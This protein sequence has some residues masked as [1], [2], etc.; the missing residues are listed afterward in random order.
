MERQDERLIRQRMTIHEKKTIN[1]SY[2]C[3]ACDAVLDEEED[4]CSD[5]LLWDGNRE[6]PGCRYADPE[7]ED[8]RPLFPYFVAEVAGDNHPSSGTEQMPAD[9]VADRKAPMG[10]TAWQT[11]GA[12]QS[13]RGRYASG[14]FDQSR[15]TFDELLL[16]E[17]AVQFAAEAHKGGKRKGS[18][19]PYIIHPVEAACI[20]ANMTDRAEVVAAAALHDVVEDTPVTVD[21]IR[22]AF[23]ES[24]ARL[25]G[26]ESEDKMRHMAASESWVLRKRHFLEHLA[27]E[28]SF[29]VKLVALTDK[30]SNIKQTVKVHAKLGSAMWQRFNQKDERVQAWYYR[31]V[32]DILKK[33][34]GETP[35]WQRL[36]EAVE[37]SFAGVEVITP[38]V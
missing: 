27:S 1:G 12:A 28:T 14:P 31:S 38:R 35:E 36:N 32:T 19:V 17:R 16:I 37:E 5:C 26:A 15:W 18:Q 22:E 29:D 30:L 6:T 23:G 13:C 2:Y 4:H 24:V 9:A 7:N 3:R 8:L 10:T 11:G 34:F 25:V 33:D 20:A 21:E